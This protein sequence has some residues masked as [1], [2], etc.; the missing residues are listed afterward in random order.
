MQLVLAEKPS[1]GAEL[2]RVLKADQKHAA[3]LKAMAT[4]SRGRLA[5]Y[6]P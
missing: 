4:S 5:T 2:A 1:V 3:I 6:S